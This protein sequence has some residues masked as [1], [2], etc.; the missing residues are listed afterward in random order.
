[1][2]RFPA[3]C[4]LACALLGQSAPSSVP[5]ESDFPKPGLSASAARRL[6]NSRAFHIALLLLAG[7]AIPGFAQTANPAATFLSFNAAE[8]GV[9]GGAAQ[10]LTASFTVSG[11]TGSFTPTAALHYGHDYTLGAVSCAGG[12]SETCTVAVTFEPTLP[13]TRKDAIFLMNGMTRLATVLLNGVGQGPMSLVQP[14]A[15][16]TSVPSSTLNTS[17]YNYVYQSVTDENGTV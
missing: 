3:L 5:Q 13:G 11:Y 17:G 15:F 14:G 12:A 6:V 16:S 2:F 10:T 8:I 4:T 9:N 7:F 1:M